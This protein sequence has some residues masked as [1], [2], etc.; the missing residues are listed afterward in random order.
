MIHLKAVTRSKA[1]QAGRAER[2][3]HGGEAAAE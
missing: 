2:A 1:Q 3:E